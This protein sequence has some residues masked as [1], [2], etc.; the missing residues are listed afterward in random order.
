MLRIGAVD[1]YE[2]AHVDEWLAG[3]NQTPTTPQG[4]RLVQQLRDEAMRTRP[5]SL[6][7]V[8]RWAVKWF[9]PE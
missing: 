7:F 3:Q 4:A 2:W 5:L 9:I 8:P 1:R 6:M